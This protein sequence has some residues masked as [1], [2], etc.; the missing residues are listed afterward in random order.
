THR[1]GLPQTKV[2]QCI[3]KEFGL[4]PDPD[5]FGYSVSI[6][7]Q[8][9]DTVTQWYATLPRPIV[10]FHYEGESSPE[11]KNLKPS[12]VKQISSRLADAGVTVVIL[13]WRHNNIQNGTSIVC[14]PKALVSQDSDHL[15]ALIEQ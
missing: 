3:A 12:Q 14:P 7:P 10:C 4:V 15:A 9:T 6:D 13:D 2:A 5:L 8:A 1:P 11:K